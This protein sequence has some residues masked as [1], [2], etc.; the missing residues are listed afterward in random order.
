MGTPAAEVRLARSKAA[1]KGCS[2]L[3]SLV[4]PV[5][6]EEDT[7][8]PFLEAVDRM[9]LDQGL[10]LDLIFVNDGST[11]GTLAAL[12]G[13]QARM[14]CLRILDL[15]RRFGKEAALT[16]GIDA[17]R[18]DVVIPMD[19]DLQDP[20]DLI[21]RLIEKWYEGYDV[22][23]AVRACRDQ[24]TVF[25]RISA[26]L[27]YRLINVIATSRIPPNAGDFRLMDRCVAQALQTIDERSRFMKGIFSWVGFPTATIEYQRPLRSAGRSK[28]NAWKLW[29]FALDGIISFSAQPLKI[30]TYVGL[31][32][33]AL[34]ILYAV[35]LI[36]RTMMFGIDV[37]GYASIMVLLLFSTALNLIS[38]GFLGEYVGR[39]FLETKK[40]PVYILREEIRAEGV[41][42]ECEPADR[43]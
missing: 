13:A 4:V 23:L 36:I 20:P 19:V 16:A 37:P 3:V 25:K 43:P 14:P 27:F 38:I 24:D 29:N 42:E 26:T 12:L 31:S 39:M 17:A 11:D 33:A 9:A 21:P 2:P 34:A 1:R 18:G 6:D 15:S 40:R 5:L 32:I 28:F 30:W 7:I 22:V 8:G 41:P 10:S 35:F